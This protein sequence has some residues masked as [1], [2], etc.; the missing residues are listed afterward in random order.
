MRST[1]GNNISNQ[2]GVIE[3][4][5]LQREPNDR[6][7]IT[8]MKTSLGWEGIHDLNVIFVFNVIFLF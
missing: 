8:G 5:R 1:K 7:A 3:I 4:K 6:S 2:V